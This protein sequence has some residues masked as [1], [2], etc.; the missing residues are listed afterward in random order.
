[1]ADNHGDTVESADLRSDDYPLSR[2]LDHILQ[3]I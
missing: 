1:M 3:A 2:S